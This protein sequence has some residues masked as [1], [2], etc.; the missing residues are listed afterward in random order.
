MDIIK[1]ITDNP[2]L[3]AFCNKILAYNTILESDETRHLFLASLI[4]ADTLVDKESC[5]ETLDTAY[6]ITNHMDFFQLE[7]SVRKEIEDYMEKT[8]EVAFKELRMFKKEEKE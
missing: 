8:I 2:K 1:K 3:V 7:D 6:F 5:Q 4:S